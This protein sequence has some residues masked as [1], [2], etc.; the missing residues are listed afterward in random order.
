MR[1]KGMISVMRIF[2]VRRD[3]GYDFDALRK[4]E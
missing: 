1:R 2:G 3:G 4:E